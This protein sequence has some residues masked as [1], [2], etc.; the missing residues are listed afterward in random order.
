MTQI[1]GSLSFR[2]NDSLILL[3]DA[4]CSSGNNIGKKE[5][6]TSRLNS[7]SKSKAGEAILTESDVE[8][9][10]RCDV[11]A[12]PMTERNPLQQM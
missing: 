9:L 8:W 6:K 7:K 3:K 12:S 2:E 4:I 11:I 1:G 10:Q 5:V